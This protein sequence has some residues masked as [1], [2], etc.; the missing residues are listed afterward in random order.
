MKYREQFKIIILHKLPSQ[1][2]SS[3]LHQCFET[4]QIAQ[5]N[6][7][8]ICPKTTPLKWNAAPMG[9]TSFSWH[10]NIKFFFIFFNPPP[11]PPPPL[12]SI[13]D[14]SIKPTYTPKFNV[15]SYHEKFFNPKKQLQLNQK[16]Y[17]CN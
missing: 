9:N 5:K 12:S 7:T 17:H 2:I 3:S 1:I 6:N 16:S 15:N 11:P 8:M 14:E 10:I 13:T 4:E